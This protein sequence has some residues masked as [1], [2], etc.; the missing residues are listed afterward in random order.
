MS[1]DQIGMLNRVAPEVVTMARGVMVTTC[2]GAGT[3]Q[4]APLPPVV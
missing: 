3:T 4:G 1:R 2:P